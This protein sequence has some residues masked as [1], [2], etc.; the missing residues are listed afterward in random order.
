MRTFLL[1]SLALVL[2]AGVT[3]ACPEVQVA[4]D[5]AQA[6]PGDQV[7]FYFLLANNGTEAIT[8]TI[9]TTIRF[10]DFTIGPISHPMELGAGFERTIEFD[11]TV[12]PPA[13]GGTLTI[14]VA[15]SAEGCPTSTSTATLEILAP[16][17]GGENPVD[18]FGQE[19]VRHGFAS[20]DQP[21]V[22]QSTW[23]EIKALVR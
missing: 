9:E 1:T 3:F 15:A 12:P 13:A 16:L 21:G 5:P 10:D 6:A 17:V 23:G 14:E 22:E 20:P 7:H 2:G 19:L 8:A 18:A 11:F 4:F